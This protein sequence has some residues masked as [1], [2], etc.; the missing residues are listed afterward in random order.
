M[1]PARA[2]REDGNVL[3]TALLVMMLQTPTKLWFAEAR[4]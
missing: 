3:I 1:N 2:L 4:R